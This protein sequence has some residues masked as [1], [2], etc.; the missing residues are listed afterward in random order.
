[1]TKNALARYRRQIEAE[2]DA[3]IYRRTGGYPDLE[4]MLADRDTPP[5]D[6]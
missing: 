6:D 1:V 3:E 5:L 2:H 4:E